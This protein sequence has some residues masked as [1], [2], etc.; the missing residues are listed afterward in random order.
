[1]HLREL[2]SRQRIDCCI[3]SGISR[4]IG[5]YLCFSF[6]FPLI[7]FVFFFLFFWNLFCNSAT[8]VSDSSRE[9]FLL[10]LCPRHGSNGLF[11]KITSRLKR[12]LRIAKTLK[13]VTVNDHTEK[14]LSSQ[15]THRRTDTHSLSLSRSRSFHL[16][17]LCLCLLWSL[18]NGLSLSPLRFHVLHLHVK[19]DWL[20]EN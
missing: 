4:N 5:R 2:A 13:A 1:M 7:R 14:V 8:R 10:D 20:G 15:M 18:C 17:S 6:I 16:Y 11:I 3:C 9:Y 12:I 19:L